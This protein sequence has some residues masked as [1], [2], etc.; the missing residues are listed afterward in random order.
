MFR[1][2]FIGHRSGPPTGTDLTVETQ[3][4]ADF[5]NRAQGVDPLQLNRGAIV[6]DLGVGHT[7][8]DRQVLTARYIGGKQQRTEAAQRQ[9]ID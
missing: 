9:Q 8:H 5:T 1:R 6:D 2:Q 3:L 7:R 4:T